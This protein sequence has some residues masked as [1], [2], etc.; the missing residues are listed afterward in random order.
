VSCSQNDC[1]RGKAEEFGEAVGVKVPS[2]RRV[3]GRLHAP[4]SGTV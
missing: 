3:F 4:Y 2:V 1:A